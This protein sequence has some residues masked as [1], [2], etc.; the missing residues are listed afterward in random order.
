M[1]HGGRRPAAPARRA[2]LLPRHV[3]AAAV[4]AQPDPE[5]RPLRGDE[6]PLAV[7]RAGRSRWRRPRRGGCGVHGRWGAAVG[8]HGA[9]QRDEQPL[10][11]R[12]P[13]GAV[14]QSRPGVPVR[15]RW[16]RRRWQRRRRSRSSG[17]PGGLQQQRPGG[18]GGRPGTELQH[19]LCRGAAAEWLPPERPRG[20]GRCGAVR[21]GMLRY[22]LAPPPPPPG[23]A[24]AVR[25]P[26]GPAAARVF[27]WRDCCSVWLGCAH[28]VG[29]CTCR[30]ADFRFLPLYS[31]QLEPA[32]GRH[33]STRTPFI[34]APCLTQPPPPPAPSLGPPPAEG[35]LLFTWGGDFAVNGG[36]AW[37]PAGGPLK[38]DSHKGC[39]GTGDKAGRLVPTLVRG[40]LEGKRVV[41]VRGGW[42]SAESRAGRGLEESWMGWGVGP[43]VGSGRSR[44]GRAI[45]PRQHMPMGMCNATCPAHAYACPTMCALAFSN[46]QLCPAPGQHTHAHARSHVP[47]TRLARPPC[48]LHAG[49]A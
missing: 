21:Y 17:Q 44:R 41:Q 15:A 28:P 30:P 1:A 33:K 37:E 40:E 6:H 29:R 49:G 38:R 32:H 18:P 31:H 45:V 46:L 39:L 43:G 2:G 3:L 48:R 10:E 24:Y 5:P 26:G 42:V 19:E 36:E 34:F 27:V 23:Q 9:G 16:R 20:R 47:R 14:G 11:Q 22:G 12:R 35:G 8:A 7:G 13:S 4:A 25:R